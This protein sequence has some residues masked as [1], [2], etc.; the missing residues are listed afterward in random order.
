MQA[1]KVWEQ[2]VP[3]RMHDIPPHPSKKEMTFPY[4]LTSYKESFFLYFCARNFDYKPDVAFITVIHTEKTSLSQDN[5]S[6]SPP[7]QPRY[8]HHK[9]HYSRKLRFSFAKIVRN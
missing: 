9:F 3:M 1:T 8:S 4:F 7:L 2:K 6:P 5:E